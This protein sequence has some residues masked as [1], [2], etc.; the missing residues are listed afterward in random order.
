[1]KGN[2]AERLPE[3]PGEPENFL[4]IREGPVRFGIPVQS[5][6]EV[7]RVPEMFSPDTPFRY[8]G[9]EVPVLT[10]RGFL[11]GIA[12]D[13]DGTERLLVLRGEPA[14]ALRVS[15]VEGFF[16]IEADA[17]RGPENIPIRGFL[18]KSLRGIARS[19]EELIFFLDPTAILKAIE[20][21]RDTGQENQSTS[22]GGR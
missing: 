1:M 22:E 17:I 12:E 8:R 5:V 14:T 19:G 7:V 3:T 21:G 9:G 13:G 10:L 6:T 15:H 4:V 11:G 18:R 16:E 20:E 2:E